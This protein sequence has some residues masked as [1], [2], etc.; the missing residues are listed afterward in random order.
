[1]DT[2]TFIV[3]RYSYADEIGSLKAAQESKR[4]PFSYSSTSADRHA[5]HGVKH[6]KTLKLRYDF[7][8]CIAIYFHL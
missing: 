1:M 4:Y 5:A 7:N 2:N 8:S 6:V 3:S